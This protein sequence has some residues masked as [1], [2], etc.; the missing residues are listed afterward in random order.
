MTA[1]RYVGF[2]SEPT[3]Y[4]IAARMHAS[5]LR[6]AGV[7][8]TARSVLIG[9]DGPFDV[10]GAAQESTHEPGPG[11]E[12]VIVHAPPSLTA[13]L[14]PADTP[15]ILLTVCETERLP[16]HWIPAVQ[17]VDE[18]WVP[19][20]FSRR[21]FEAVASC[22]VQVVNH[23]VAPPRG[24][25]AFPGIPD[26]IFLFASVFE[27]QDRK[28]PDGLLS[29]FTEAFQGRSDVGLLIKT[30]FR[31]GMPREEAIRTTREIVEK[32][33]AGGGPKVWLV[34][35]DLSPAALGSLYR[36]ADAYV[37]L[38]RAEG[39]G[40]CMAE[41]MLAGTPV[42]ATGWS[43]NLEFMDARSAWLVGCDLVPL[44]Q[45]WVRSRELDEGMQWAQPRHD[46]AVEAMRACVSNGAERERR[47]AAGQSRVREQ[48]S[49]TV[50]GA[51]M[52]ELLQRFEG[53][54]HRVS[55]PQVRSHAQ[56]AAGRMV[57]RDWPRPTW[58]LLSE[59]TLVSIVITCHNYGR[60]LEEAAQSALGQT[61]PHI[62]VIVVDDGSTDETLEV[63]RRLPVRVI[64]G[65][66]AGVA[67][68]RNRGAAIARGAYL[69]F[70]DA[71]DALE[72]DY[73][74]E[75]VAA[76]K[77]AAPDTAY[78]Y[79]KA[80]LFGSEE[81]IFESCAFD[82]E[83]LLVRNF[84]HASALMRREAFVAVSGVDP[85]FGQAWEDHDLWLRMLAAGYSGVLV[86]SALLRY[87]RHGTSRNSLSDASM[88]QLRWK[89]LGAHPG[90]YSRAVVRQPVRSLAA[91]LRHGSD[92]LRAEADAP[93]EVPHHDLGLG[94]SVVVVNWNAKD[95]LVECLA[96]LH[97][98]TEG[99]FEVVVVDQGSTDGSQ[100]MVRERFPLVKL[101][102]LRS[103]VGFAQGC[104]R[105]LEAATQSWVAMLNNDAV[106]A[107]DWIE[108]LR[109]A[110]RSASHDVGMIQCK[111][112]FKNRPDR[113]NSTGILLHAD[114]SADDRGFNRLDQQEVGATEVFCPSAAA[115]LYR[116]TM[117]DS[118]RSSS[119]VLDC[120]YF[121]YMEDVDLGWRA[122]LCGWNAIYEPTAVVHHTFHGTVNRHRSRFV[123][124]SVARNRLRTLAKNA[125]LRFVW[126]TRRRSAADI[127]R[128][129]AWHG[130]QEMVSLAGAIVRAVRQRREVTRMARVSR[131]QVERRWAGR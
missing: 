23:P 4:G 97:R 75:C 125:S 46:E 13:G 66:R 119:G 27:W 8:V 14:L 111:V 128:L 16:A 78:A 68:A 18:I 44:R 120:A 50:V 24:R 95:E 28:N 81:G 118:L 58:M 98:Q 37:S 32:G 71:D 103:N 9:P 124:S 54:P 80:R 96:A 12:P 62:E 79:T 130:P 67:R 85:S 92:K 51:R 84:V 72:P 41:A 35:E 59:A 31:M 2:F 45:H 73:V 131:R 60:F 69:M 17:S 61:W 86:P 36:R 89:L 40:L 29:A 74:S 90:L 76:L 82:P 113:L 117:L 77:T 11:Q 5:A 57:Q 25:R 91:W 64:S 87:R 122:R 65:P 105:G 19:S 1:A 53:E 39:F 123:E 101:M 10:A 107:A 70:L 48:L 104:N 30:G 115:A 99:G 49:R 102:D 63:A 6:H 43:G 3:G 22:P 34:T 88:R 116:R 121:M 108:R 109:S 127:A 106:P 15:T 100:Q 83:L 20:E 56:A 7:R 38:H 112:L 52:R 110:A 55:A 42:I 129:V 114:G 94:I 126:T 21:A 26:D 47:A 93:A 33:R